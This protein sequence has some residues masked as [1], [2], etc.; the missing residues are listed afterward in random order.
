MCG[1][2]GKISEEGFGAKVKL[3]WSEVRMSMPSPSFL[4]VGNTD[5]GEHARRWISSLPISFE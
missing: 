2:T 5:P 1:I 4:L 3:H